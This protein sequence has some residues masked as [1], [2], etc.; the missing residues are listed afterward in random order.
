MESCCAIGQFPVY[1]GFL[2]KQFSDGGPVFLLRSFGQARIPGDAGR[3]Q[4]ARQCNRTNHDY[5]NSIKSPFRSRKRTTFSSPA[6]T[7]STPALFSF[8]V[9]PRLSNPAIRKHIW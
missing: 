7:T 8:S 3:S 1:V 2:L 6:G 4:D 5:V 9:T